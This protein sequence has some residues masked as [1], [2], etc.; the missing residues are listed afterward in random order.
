VYICVHVIVLGFTT[1]YFTTIPCFYIYFVHRRGIKYAWADSTIFFV[2]PLYES[3]SAKR[4]VHYCLFGDTFAMTGEGWAA[5]IINGLIFES[6]F[7]AVPC[8]VRQKSYD[9]IWY[10]TIRYYMIWCDTIRYDTMRYDTLWY[11]MIYLLTAI[12]L[13][14]GGSSAV[15]IY[16]QTIHRMIRN[17]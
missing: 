3:C 17:K 13:S 10:D 8:K 14:P 7:V 16:T 6:Y 11:D 2:W 9:M 15:H 1:K 12:G 4:F 5:S